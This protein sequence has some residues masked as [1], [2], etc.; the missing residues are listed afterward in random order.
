MGIPI[1]TTMLISFILQLTQLPFKLTLYRMSMV[2]YPPI[3]L[4]AKIVCSPTMMGKCAKAFANVVF[5]GLNNVPPNQIFNALLC[6][7]TM[8]TTAR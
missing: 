8:I 5:G 7:R 2:V 1:N 3:M 6:K 4:K